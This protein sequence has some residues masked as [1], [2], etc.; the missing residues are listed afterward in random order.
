MNVDV[1]TLPESSFHA[2]S[3]L[4]PNIVDNEIAGQQRVVDGLNLKG[5][6]AFNDEI[7]KW[8]SAAALVR[9][10][11]PKATLPAKPISPNSWVVVVQDGKIGVQPGKWVVQVQSGPVYGVC[12]DL[13]PLVPTPTDFSGRASLPSQPTQDQKLD[14]IAATV[15]NIE[16]MLKEALGVK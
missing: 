16:K 3:A 10:A 4:F 5:K 1:S 6:A 12:P 9:N 11:D 7:A 2:F 15:Q 14:S 13:P 8:L